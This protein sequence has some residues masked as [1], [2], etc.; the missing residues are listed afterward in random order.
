MRITGFLVS[1]VAAVLLLTSVS[2]AAQLPREIVPGQTI[3]T[4]G[5]SSGTPDL[6]YFVG[7]T[8]A[9]VKFKVKGPGLVSIALFTSDGD[10]MLEASG[11]GSANLEAVLSQTEAF[12]VA[13]ARSETT[14][15]YTIAMTATEP[16][17]HLALFSKNVGYGHDMETVSGTSVLWRKC[18]VEPGVMYKDYMGPV[19]SH[20]ELLRGGRERAYVNDPGVSTETKVSWDGNVI[21]REST[22]GGRTSTYKYPLG[23]GTF[24]RPPYRNFR[25]TGYMCDQNP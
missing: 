2:A 16:D 21:S 3:S 5:N 22:T 18:W 25:Y 4:K 13:V 9:T 15:P 19:A 11:T 10:Q 20:V 12:H 8:G 1:S 23:D 24:A 14:S 6:Y 17:F 7:A